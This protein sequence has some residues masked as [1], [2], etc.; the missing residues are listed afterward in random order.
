MELNLEHILDKFKLY[1]GEAMDG[2][3]PKRDALCRSLCQESLEWAQRQIRP[4]A[5][6]RCASGAESLAAAEA[7][8]QLALL[9]QSAGPEVVSSPELK[10]E[11]GSRAEYAKRLCQEKREGCKGI[12]ISDGFYFGRA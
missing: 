2:Q 4:D 12:L 11:L 1:S 8:Y 3:E 9:D 5:G 7:F 10:V 6:Q